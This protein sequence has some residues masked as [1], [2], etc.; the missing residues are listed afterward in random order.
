M[1]APMLFILPAVLLMFALPVRADD[2]NPDLRAPK[3]ENTR[4]TRIFLYI[5][6]SARMIDYPDVECILNCDKDQV[7]FRTQD[8]H[9][10]Q[11]HGP[12]TVIQPKMAQNTTGSHGNSGGPRFFDLK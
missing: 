8:G 10:V 9:V 4:L 2:S 3:S 7:T 11:H 1:K 5:P 12:Y 6:G